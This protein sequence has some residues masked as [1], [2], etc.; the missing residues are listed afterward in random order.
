MNRIEVYFLAGKIKYSILEA[1][2]AVGL[3]KILRPKYFDRRSVIRTENIDDLRGIIMVF[4]Q[5]SRV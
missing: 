2:F 3:L 4:D 1:N 5:Y